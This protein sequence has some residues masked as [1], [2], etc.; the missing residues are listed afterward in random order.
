[1]SAKLTK[2]F[3]GLK[4]IDFVGH[5]VGKGK[6]TPREAKVVALLA[7]PVPN[8]KKQLQS[9]IGLANYFSRYIPKFADISC[10]LT[11][12]LQKSKKFIWSVE[13][14]NSYNKIKEC[15]TKSPVLF[16][17]DF[18]KPFF[19]FVDASNVAVGSALCQLD[20]DDIY[21]PICYASHKLNNAERNYNIT[22]REL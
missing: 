22:D 10:N 1:M 11:C 12:L 16:I 13:A 5:T 20:S 14:D 9:F 8:S 6:M 17:A 2:C 7:M 21:H 3:F 4:E 18:K 15:L 19:I